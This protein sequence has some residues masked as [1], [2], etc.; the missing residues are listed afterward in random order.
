MPVPISPDVLQAVNEW[1]S[2]FFHL[3]TPNEI[4]TK[5]TDLK[6]AEESAKL[7][8]S[9]LLYGER[10]GNLKSYPY[11][12]SGVSN[13]IKTLANESLWRYGELNPPEDFESTKEKGFWIST[14]KTFKCSTCR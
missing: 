8:S 3:T 13:Q 9:T 7:I 6:Q 10:T 5:S 4:L 11:D 1:S 12:S 2:S 14:G